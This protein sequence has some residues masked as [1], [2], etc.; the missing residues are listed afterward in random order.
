MSKWT[1]EELG[2]GQYHIVFNEMHFQVEKSKL[3]DRIAELLADRKL[4]MIADVRDESADDV[5]IV[6]VPKSRNIDSKLIMESYR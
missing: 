4:P 1:K 3:L 5:R 2:Q 6:F